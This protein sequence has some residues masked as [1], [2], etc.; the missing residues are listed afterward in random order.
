MRRQLILLLTLTLPLIGFGELSDWIANEFIAKDQ[1]PLFLEGVQDKVW[2]LNQLIEAPKEELDLLLILNAQSDDQWTQ[3]CAQ[4]Q[5]SGLNNIAFGLENVSERMRQIY[6]DH[7]YEQQT[8]GCDTPYS[9]RLWLSPFIEN[10]A[11]QNLASNKRGYRE[12]FAGVTAAGDYQ[13]PEDVL[14]TVG[15]SFANSHLKMNDEQAAAQCN[16]YAGSLGSIF[17]LSNFVIDTLLS[18]SYNTIDMNRQMTFSVAT[19]YALGMDSRKASSSQGANQILAHVGCNYDF[20]CLANYTD[21][22]NLTLYPFANLDYLY[23]MGDSYQENGAL[24]LNLS[25]Q[26]KSSDLLRPEMG[27]GMT[28]TQYTKQVDLL[29]DIAASYVHEFRFAGENNTVSFAT[30]SH[31]FSTKGLFPTNNLFCPTTRLRFAFPEKGISCTLGYHGAYGTYFSENAG[32][33]EFRFSF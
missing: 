16:T 23:V 21:T 33:A 30:S 2:K 5:P 4:M 25:V 3:S 1:D 26:E 29:L 17:K 11:Q 6:S 18:Y 22:R 8:L 15:F 24:S 27:I 7:L 32:E 28:L 10:V 12:H 31:S 13:L 14:F 20:I 9:W 19:P